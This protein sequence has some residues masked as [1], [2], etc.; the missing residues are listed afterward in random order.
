MIVVCTPPSI[1]SL[2]HVCSNIY[3][4]YSIE[5]SILL[6]VTYVKGWGSLTG[7]NEVKVNLLEGGETTLS[8]KNIL[9]ATGSDISSIPGLTIDEERC[10]LVIYEESIAYVPINRN[11]VV[12][13]RHFWLSYI[14]R[15]AECFMYPYH[16]YLV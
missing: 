12:G 7:Q 15:S 8:A 2:K 6:Q 5:H 9:I 1:S 3:R 16:V 13:G 11:I 4:L 14:L 10:E